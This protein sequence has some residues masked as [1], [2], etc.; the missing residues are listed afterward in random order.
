MQGTF[1][2]PDPE[3]VHLNT[4]L[5]QAFPRETLKMTMVQ[6]HELAKAVGLWTVAPT[7]SKTETWKR[8]PE[9]PQKSPMANPVGTMTVTRRTPDGGVQ[10]SGGDRRCWAF[11]ARTFGA[12]S[13]C[14]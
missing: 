5:L 10:W 13:S 4:Q 8:L 12:A 9:A 14:L 11:M 2:L 7:P 1:D 6:F 3:Q